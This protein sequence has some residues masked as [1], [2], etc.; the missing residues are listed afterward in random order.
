MSSEPPDSSPVVVAVSDE[1]AMGV[2]MERIVGVARRT[3]ESEGAR[4]EISIT[5]VDASRMAGLN[6]Q[7]MGKPR[8]TDVLSFPIDGLASADASLDEG[9][10]W[11]IGEVVLC[12]EVA[13]DQ[14]QGPVEE[15]LDLLV[16]HGVLHL[17]GYDHDTESGAEQMRAREFRLTG[18]AGAQA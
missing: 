9:P 1:Q 6:G 13:A 5:L 4:G 2:D 8:P 16:A 15:E 17:L 18:R 10:P 11:L 7:H 12:P 3:A 14:A